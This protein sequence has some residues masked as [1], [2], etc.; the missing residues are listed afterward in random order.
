MGVHKLR[1]KEVI[2]EEVSDKF[3]HFRT[4]AQCQNKAFALGSLTFLA[5]GSGVYIAQELMRSKLPFGRNAFLLAPVL[6]GGL[7]GYYVTQHN[8]RLCQKMWILL[9]EKEAETASASETLTEDKK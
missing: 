6:L 4:Y 9:E 1:N 7:S 8:T 2:A 3:P 5:M